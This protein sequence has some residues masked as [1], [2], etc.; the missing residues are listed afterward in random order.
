MFFFWQLNLMETTI[1]LSVAKRQLFEKVS[2]SA[3]AFEFLGVLVYQ[4]TN[5]IIHTWTSRLFS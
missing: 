3:V 2:W 1:Q 5:Y 4:L